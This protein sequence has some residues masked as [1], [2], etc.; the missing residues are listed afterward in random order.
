MIRFLR[1]QLV[2]AHDQLRFPQRQIVQSLNERH[3][4][5]LGRMRAFA[6]PTVIGHRSDNC[7]RFLVVAQGKLLGPDNKQ[8]GGAPP[9][10]KTRA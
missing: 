2:E 9:H 4:N 7:I 10:S 3:Q 1:N 8:S 6:N 5:N